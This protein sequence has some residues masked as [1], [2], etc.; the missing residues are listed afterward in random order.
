MLFVF[1]RKCTRFDH[2]LHDD[3]QVEMSVQFSNKCVK[4]NRKNM[5]ID[6]GNYTFK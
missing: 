3:I 4:S 2:I 6:D 5:E 1:Y